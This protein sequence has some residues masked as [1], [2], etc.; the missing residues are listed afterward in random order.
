MK[1][2][3][4]PDWESIEQ[5]FRGIWLKEELTPQDAIDSYKKLLKKNY[6]DAPI[7]QELFPII[8]NYNVEKVKDT[9]Y[10]IVKL[11]CIQLVF[12]YRKTKETGIDDKN[13]ST[14]A[15]KLEKNIE[16]EKSEINK[17]LIYLHINDKYPDSED[18]GTMIEEIKIK[19]NQSDK[20]IRIKH[21][22]N[23]QYLVTHFHNIPLIPIEYEYLNEKS[24]YKKRKVI[25]RRLRDFL[26]EHTHFKPV[27]DLK[28]FSISDECCNLIFDLLDVAKV[29][30]N[31]GAS[32][33]YTP[34][35][36]IRSILQER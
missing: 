30:K 32:V 29:F 19:T 16:K 6:S 3:L 18:A 7:Y 27:D 25:V 31:S 36:H 20:Y 34:P 9:L 15:I 26:H 24:Y 22:E 11:I 23:I 17:L 21:F 1:R 2:E 4:S 35:Q 14:K 10:T 5:F 8:S 13:L 12:F 33:G 28:K